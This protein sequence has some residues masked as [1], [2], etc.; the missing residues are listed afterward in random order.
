MARSAANGYRTTGQ[1]ALRSRMKRMHAKAF[2]AY[3]PAALH[4]AIKE[5]A[6][7]Q[8]AELGGQANMNKVIVTNL[9]ESIKDTLSADE[10]EE[11]ESFLNSL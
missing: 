11:C 1:H 3:M 9:Y 6:T 10:R 8:A 2:N 7:K 5:A 4:A